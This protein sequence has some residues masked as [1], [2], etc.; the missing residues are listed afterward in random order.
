MRGF[1]LKEPPGECLQAG[2][3]GLDGV[4]DDLHFHAGTLT[5]GADI[6]TAPAATVMSRSSMK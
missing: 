4:Q 2:G 5:P 1:R 3:I 6:H